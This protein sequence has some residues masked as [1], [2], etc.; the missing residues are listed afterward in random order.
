[1]IRKFFIVIKVFLDYS[2][3]QKVQNFHFIVPLFSLIICDSVAYRN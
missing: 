1:M 2:E 3:L